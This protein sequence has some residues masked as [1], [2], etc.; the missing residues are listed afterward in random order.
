MRRYFRI[1]GYQNTRYA[2]NRSD[3]GLVYTDDPDFDPQQLGSDVRELEDYETDRWYKRANYV[4]KEEGDEPYYIRPV[5]LCK[6]DWSTLRYLIR[7]GKI[8]PDDETDP[9]CLMLVLSPESIAYD[10]NY[11]YD[12]NSFRF[13]YY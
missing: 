5:E 10:L 13:L 12:R 6:L 7:T 2:L 4:A 8:K 3:F 1:H 9:R 11:R